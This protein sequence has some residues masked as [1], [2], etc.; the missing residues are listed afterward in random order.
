RGTKRSAW[1][2]RDRS[3]GPHTI[4]RI[5]KKI[6]QKIIKKYQYSTNK[7]Q[8]TFENQY[9][10]RVG[11]IDHIQNFMQKLNDQSS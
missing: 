3:E 7:I 6:E 8:R 4:L 10:I 9:E 1:T 5:D 2:K 11:H